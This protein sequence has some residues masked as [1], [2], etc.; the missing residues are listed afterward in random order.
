[1]KTMVLTGIRRM[2]PSE[3]PVPVP[4]SGSD[5][6]I[7]MKAVGVCGSDIH[8]YT[9]GKIG[10]QVVKYP[11]PVGHEGAGEVVQ[12]GSAVTRV[13]VGDRVAIDPAMPCFRC[14]QC[15][16]GRPHTCRNL[17]FLGNPGQAGGCLTEYIVMPETSCVPIPSGMTFD[18]AAVS[19]PLAIGVYAVRLANM[20]L[21]G[22]R[23]GILGFGP[24]GMSVLIPAL[25]KGAGF[26][27]VTDKIEARL[28]LARA[29]GA[30]W[31]GNPD[32][33]DVVAEIRQREENLLDVVFECCGQQ[34]AVNQ[35]I[36][37]LKP[38]GKLMLIG[39]PEMDRWSLPVDQLRHKEICIQNVRR[40]NDSVEE[41]LR[42]IREGRIK[43]G[44]MVTHRFPFERTRE[45]FE[46]VSRYGDGVMKA[47][48]YFD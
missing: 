24:I 47:M 42:L 36:E 10:S 40:Q 16:A 31:T 14:D 48:I 25:E 34:D 26:V 28:A 11:F 29:S 46:L 8:Y 45:A 41:A 4:E 17:R 43:A 5:V 7:R 2:E 6:L 12:V 33:E 18:E 19:E 3:S 15:L 35:A 22:K 21:A 32:R 44:S 1:M 37:L 20:E 27:Y 9:T 30:V 39:I 38:G 23:I 13:Q